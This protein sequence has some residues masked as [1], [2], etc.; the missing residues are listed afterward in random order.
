M[1]EKKSSSKILSLSFLKHF[2]WLY[3]FYFSAIQHKWEEV[4]IKLQKSQKRNWTIC[5]G[6]RKD[7]YMLV[8]ILTSTPHGICL[9]ICSHFLPCIQ[10]FRRD[11]KCLPFFPHLFLFLTFLFFF[12]YYYFFHF[13]FLK[14][15]GINKRTKNFPLSLRGLYLELSIF[16]VS[17]TLRTVT[18]YKNRY[19]FAIHLCTRK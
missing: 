5:S 3:D 19:F 18:H 17:Q 15:C 1:T 9:L 8:P 2:V 12:Y 4:I 13:F 6:K 11:P 7:T 10:D 16:G 14:C